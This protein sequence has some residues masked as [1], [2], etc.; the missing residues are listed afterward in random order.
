M[1]V[2]KSPL[3]KLGVSLYTTPAYYCAS[4]HPINTDK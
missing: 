4:V 1:N 3:N 2:Q